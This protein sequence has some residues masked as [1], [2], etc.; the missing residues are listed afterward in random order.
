VLVEE[1]TE[2][3]GVLVAVSV[4]VVISTEVVVSTEV[5]SV[6]VVVPVEIAV[7]SLF[8]EKGVLGK[9]ISH[10]ASNNVN[11]TVGIKKCFFIIL[12]SLYFIILIVKCFKIC[13]C[14]GFELH[15]QL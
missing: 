9:T 13:I 4:D 1:I 8:E 7:P 15:P 10:E 6:E 2:L 3:D 14:R 5:M 11:K 12:F